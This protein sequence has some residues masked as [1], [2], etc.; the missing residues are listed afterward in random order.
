MKKYIIT[1]FETIKGEKDRITFYGEDTEVSD[2]Y[3]T[4][5][6]LY[7]HR[8]ALN[9]ALFNYWRAD[10][11]YALGYNLNRV[12]EH[13]EADKYLHKAVQLRSSEPVFKDEMA[14]NDAI[15]AISILS[16]PSKKDD[17]EAAIKKIQHLLFAIQEYI[18]V[19]EHL[20]H[21]ERKKSIAYVISPIHIGESQNDRA[22]A[23]TLPIGRD[24]SLAG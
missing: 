1:K 20:F 18:L 9:I 11:A 21:Y 3:H 14:V 6:E 2:E 19:L 15:L 10:I 12:G 16:D 8:R 4:M 22:Y 7:D 17:K 24:E 23:K 13:Q 5:H